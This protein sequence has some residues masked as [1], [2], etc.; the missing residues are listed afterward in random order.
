[1]RS[2][3]IAFIV[4]ALVIA[5]TSGKEQKNTVEVLTDDTFA[6]KTKKGVWMV[7]FYTESSPRC[8]RVMERWNALP[9]SSRGNLHLAAIDCTKNPKICAEVDDYPTVR[10]Y[11]EER[12]GFREYQGYDITTNTLLDFAQDNSNIDLKLVKIPDSMQER[13]EDLVEQYTILSKRTD[14]LNKRLSDIVRKIERR[15]EQ[16]FLE[17]VRRIS[18]VLYLTPTNYSLTTK[19]KWLVMLTSP[20]WPGG[21][22]LNI[23]WEAFATMYEHYFK[24]A[25]INCDRYS[26]FCTLNGLHEFITILAYDDG[27][28][29][30]YK[31]DRTADDIEQFATKLFVN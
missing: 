10:L 13:L 9:A 20:F 14:D 15:E 18:K 5:I 16:E 22:H 29:T 11:S 31:G 26:E 25:K 12:E 7:L 6:E 21:K 19:G 4:A 24:V 3:Y 28:V 27:K 8:E 1:M 2:L 17:E 23:P 30:E